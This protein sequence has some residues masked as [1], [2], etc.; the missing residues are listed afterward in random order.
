MCYYCDNLKCDKLVLLP[1]VFCYSD[2]L[3]CS[4]YFLV[5]FLKALKLGF[6]GDWLVQLVERATLDLSVVGSSPMS[7]VDVA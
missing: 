4:V 3:Y 5:L 1:F 7:Y 2:Y 6:R